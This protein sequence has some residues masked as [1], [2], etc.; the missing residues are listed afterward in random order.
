MCKA[1]LVI[2]CLEG[3]NRLLC[4]NRALRTYLLDNF[5]FPKYGFASLK[6]A[7][8]DFFPNHF[9][10]FPRYRMGSEVTQ[11]FVGSGSL[12]CFDCLYFVLYTIRVLKKIEELF[13]NFCHRSQAPH[14]YI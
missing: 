3:E 6:I 8:F 1:L 12:S 5:L 4:R 2:W 10:F 14:C 11:M 7:L 13:R 9:V